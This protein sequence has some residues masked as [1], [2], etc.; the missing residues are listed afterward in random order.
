M[1][2]KLLIF[3]LTYSNREILIYKNYMPEYELVAAVV[4]S[5]A[6]LQ[7]ILH[8]FDNIESVL[9]TEEY[10]NALPMCDT[11]LFLDCENMDVSVSMY[12]NYIQ[13]AKDSC[14]KVVFSKK[15]MDF[16]YGSNEGENTAYYTKNTGEILIPKNGYIKYIDFPA[17]G[18]MGLGDFCNKFCCEVE[19]ASFFRDKGYNV[20]HFGSKDFDGVILEKRYPEF[21]FKQ[22]YSITQRILGWNQY[23]FELCSR[24]KPDLIVLGMPGGIMPLNNK[25]LNE[26]GEIP[27]I[28]SN[29]IR[30]DTGI[31][32]SYFYEK[33][34]QKYLTEYKNYCKYKLNC[35]IEWICV[36]NSSCRFNPDSEESVLEYL[37]YEPEIADKMVVDVEDEEN[38]RLFSVLN[39]R[40]K[41]KMCQQLYEELT[42][43]VSAF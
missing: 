40:S 4:K 31:L 26:F 24:E 20:I 3:P 19:V 34:D 6:D 29:G 22:E 7:F 2:K 30:V 10:E 13:K 35:N 43:S 9:I 15:C 11:V 5:Q 32:C 27:Y 25:I 37:H 21:L 8:K 42:E 17:I 16:L 18:V 41:E 36:S 23:L 33:V 12:K 39:D 1:K 38:I 14:K 28:I